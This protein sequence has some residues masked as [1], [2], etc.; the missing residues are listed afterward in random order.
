MQRRRPPPGREKGAGVG[1]AVEKAENKRAA[2]AGFL[3]VT[4]RGSAADIL[5]FFIDVRLRGV[6]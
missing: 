3:R 4:G 5:Q 1:A 6:V 2:P